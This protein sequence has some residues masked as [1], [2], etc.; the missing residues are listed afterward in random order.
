MPVTP[1]P[2]PARREQEAAAGQE[3]VVMKLTAF[4]SVVGSA[5]DGSFGLSVHRKLEEAVAAFELEHGVRPKL[6]CITPMLAT[7]RDGNPRS[8]NCKCHQTMRRAVQKNGRRITHHIVNARFLRYVT[9]YDVAMIDAALARGAG[10]G[11][12]GEAVQVDPIKPPRK[13]LELSVRS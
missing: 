11:R 10:G 8:S 5:A 12:R 1:R 3:E 4:A 13:R 6:T 9:W 2:A 7:H